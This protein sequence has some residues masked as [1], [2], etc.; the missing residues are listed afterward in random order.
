MKTGKSF[1]VLTGTI[2]GL[3]ALPLPATGEL[4]VRL[5]KAI[6]ALLPVWI[7]VILVTATG[8]LFQGCD[9][10]REH[11]VPYVRV[12]VSFNVLHHNLSAPGLSAQFSRHDLGGSAGY[13][14]II[15]YRLSNDEFRAYDRACPCNPHNC[16]VSIEE[17]NPVLAFAPEC[18]SR[19]I[20]TD[21]SV[22]EGPSRFP[23]REYRTSFDPHTNRLMIS[24]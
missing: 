2:S 18:E 14:G 7:F 5:M 11:P 17:D 13:Q 9:K 24:N 12:T 19:F 3:P 8:L 20:L 15:V 16:I 10:D 21:G 1:S 23:L 6:R 4:F 22:V